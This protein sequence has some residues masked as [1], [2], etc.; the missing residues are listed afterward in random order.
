MKQLLLLLS[1]VYLLGAG[2]ARQGLPDLCDMELM[3][4]LLCTGE[5]AAPACCPLVPCPFMPVCTYMI[6]YLNMLRI[7]HMDCFLND[8]RAQAHM[9]LQKA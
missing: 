5:Y 3:L 9:A 1:R 2:C 7:Y 4:C 8:V 6:I